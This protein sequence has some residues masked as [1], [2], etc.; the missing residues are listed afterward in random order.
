M[1]WGFAVLLSVLILGTSLATQ[2][3]KSFRDQQSQFRRVRIASQEKDEVLRKRFVEAG[4]PYPPKAIFSCAFKKESLV[5]LWVSASEGGSYS[6]VHSY[7][8]CTTSGS[9]GPKRRY[10]NGQVPEG[11]YELD[12]FN[13]QSNFFLRIHI[14]YP[15]PS[16][17]IPGS[18][19]NP[20]GNIYL[21]GDCASISCIPI[22]DDGIKEVYWV[23]VLARSSGQRHIPLH[24]FPA[25]LTDSEFREL[26][27]S[28]RSVPE[29]VALWANIKE[30]FDYF[31][32]NHRPPAISVQKDGMYAFSGET[33]QRK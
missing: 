17:R 5:E 21:H 4:L 8:I 3:S 2:D 25:R 26:A 23:C 19:Q 24:V 29:V 31:K 13:P 11:F 33:S 28:Y 12:H 20:G 15:N 1:K 30:G 22:T 32:K 6:L 7:T 16:D 14:S 9:L 27:N 10:N 18:H